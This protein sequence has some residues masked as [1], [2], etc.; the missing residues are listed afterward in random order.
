MQI[1]KELRR[2]R[3][4]Y[5]FVVPAMIYTLT[6][7]YF[8]IPYMIIA[9]E[10]FNYTT[11]IRSPWVGLQNFKYF[12]NS[13]RAGVVT[14]NT[15]FL[16][17]LFL[18]TGTI[19]A[20]LVALLINEMRFKT[21]ARVVQ[22]ITLLP[23]FLSWVVVSYVLNSLLSS[24]F[25]LINKIL[26][27]MGRPAVR[28][29]SVASYWPA[30]LTVV[31]LAKNTGYNSIVYLGAITGIDEG[32]YEAAVVDGASNFQRV[33][34]ITLPMLMPTVCIMSL[35]SIGRI[36]YGDFSMLYA[37]V[38]DNSMLLDTTDVIDTYVFRM[39]RSTGNPS[40]AM[41]IGVYQSIMGF[42]MVFSA[43]YVTRR[44]FPEGALF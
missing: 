4:C 17:V 23:R 39:L 37:L 35:L 15:L 14:Y 12:F 16:S 24:K 2:N 44:F 36:F 34:Y 19:S 1:L 20:V 13:T 22:S 29:Y 5:L 9:F 32:I 42:I 6:F 33:I 11:G 3:T 40:M 26:E 43:N 38:Q 27:A 28:W 41:A 8:T 7:S 18:I 30:I 25:G 10:K 21:Y 31:M